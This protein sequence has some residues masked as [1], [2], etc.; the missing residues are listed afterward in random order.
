MV[1]GVEVLLDRSRRLLFLPYIKR[2]SLGKIG[3]VWQL[4]IQLVKVAIYFCFSNVS[5]RAEDIKF[6]SILN[7]I[8]LRAILD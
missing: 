3:D 2:T 4:P 1:I 5:G 7:D 8:V 6:I